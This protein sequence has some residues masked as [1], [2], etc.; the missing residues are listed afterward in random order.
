MVRRR[1][2]RRAGRGDGRL[3]GS[4]GRRRIGQPSEGRAGEDRME[5][6]LFDAG[7]FECGTVQ[8]PLDYNDP[9][10]ATISLA[11]VRLPATDRAH[12]IGSL[13]LNPGGPGGPGVD[14]TLFAGPVL[15]TAEGAQ[16][17][18]RLLAGGAHGNEPTAS[19]PA[20]GV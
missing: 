11:L 15:Y 17:A 18:D 19:G 8:V 14:F 3:R 12:R 7:P 2:V 4:P 5:Q 16:A 20:P 13:F 10:G 6:V 1:G 9:N